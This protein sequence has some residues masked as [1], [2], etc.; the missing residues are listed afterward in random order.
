MNTETGN[1]ALP[2]WSRA[3]LTRLELVKGLA[4]AE[5]TPRDRALG[6]AI[7]AKLLGHLP[8]RNLVRDVA[9][10][11]GARSG[12]VA[13][14]TDDAIGISRLVES[15]NRV[16]TSLACVS[17]LEL[18]FMEI[19]P[20]RMLVEQLWQV[21]GCGY[22]AGEPKCLKTYSIFDMALAIVAE[23][24][25]FGRFQ[26]QER[27]PVLVVLEETKLGEARQ[28]IEYLTQGAGPSPGH[29]ADFHLVIQQRMR[30]DREDDQ[31]RIRELCERHRPVM[32]FF[33]PL[34]RLRRGSENQQEDLSPVLGFLR[35][36]QVEFKTAVAVT[37]HLAKPGGENASAARTGHRIR[38]TSDQYAW[39]D[40]A[41]YFT[42][43]RSSDRVQVE[44]EHREAPEPEAF[45]IGLEST[46]S[47]SGLAIRLTHESGRL[48]STRVTALRS[49]ILKSLEESPCGLKVREVHDRVSGHRKTV[50]DT[51]TSLAEA[52]EIVVR[53]E[54]RADPR[55][56]LRVCK[57]CYAPAHV[58]P[59]GQE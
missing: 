21:Q 11:L 31:E 39:L 26:V 45:T 35:E 16:Q 20:P 27:G 48:V 53:D 13:S 14:I 33:D 10:L 9:I 3:I 46:D 8:T 18:L 32:C 7:E 17:A 28:R 22:L 57:V 15:G 51:I 36:L 5:L 50:Q 41:M 44:V 24:R 12:D 25:V 38:G 58:P 43:N 54:K 52:G 19:E 42:R 56:Q 55:G 29:L 2:P 34:A 1:G 23:G 40:C 37:H 4:G 47:D 59:L 49:K 6:F 30:L